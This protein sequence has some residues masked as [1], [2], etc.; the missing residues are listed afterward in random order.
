MNAMKQHAAEVLCPG[1]ADELIKLIE[2]SSE[3]D[4]PTLEH[5]VKLFQTVPD[6]YKIPVLS[7]LPLHDY[8][9]EELMKK[10]GCSKY[11]VDTARKYVDLYGPMNHDKPQHDIV[12]SRLDMEKVEHFLDFICSSGML[13]DVAVGTSNLKPDCG[14]EITVARAVRT[15]LRSHVIQLYVDYCKGQDYKP[16]SERKLFEILDLTKASQRKALSGLDNFVADGVEA[17]ER[18]SEIVSSIVDMP[19]DEKTMTKKKLEQ[20]KRYLKGKYLLDLSKESVIGTHCSTYSLSDPVNPEFSCVCNHDHDKLCDECQNMREVLDLVTEKIKQ[21]TLGEGDKNELLYDCMQA[22]DHIN[23]WQRHIVRGFQQNLAK[24]DIANNLEEDSAIWLCDWG[25]KIL[26]MKYREKMEDWFGKRGISFHIDC[27]FVPSATSVGEFRKA[28][29]FTTLDQCTQDMYAVSCISENVLRAV[30]KDFPNVT[31]IY[32]RSDNAGCYSGSA[33]YYVKSNIASKL[34]LT[35]LRTDFSEAQ[36][37]K[38]Q[39]DRE[40]AVAKHHMRAYVDAG[41]DIT[42]AMDIKHALEWNGGL[43]NCKVSVV[44]LTPEEGCLGKVNIPMVS[45]LHSAANSDLGVQVWQYYQIGEGRKLPTKDVPF[46]PSMEIVQDFPDEFPAGKKT[47]TGRTKKSDTIFFCPEISCITSFPSE[48]EV[49]EHLLKAEHRKVDDIAL[50]SSDKVRLAYAMTVTM[51]NQAPSTSTSG[52]DE[53]DDQIPEMGWARKTRRKVKQL[54]PQQKDWL[55]D[56]YD[57]GEKSKRKANPEQ[58]VKLMRKAEK[59]NGG[60]T[61]SPDEYLRKEQICSFFSRLTAIRRK[62]TTNDSDNATID[63]QEVRR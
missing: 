63:D 7:T 58:V 42:T 14:E 17:F 3:D 52:Q 15:N 41:H 20:A 29:Y 22:T 44:K 18:M 47:Q 60:K 61:F 53:L 1:Q 59:H 39:C 54:T 45:T 26:P 27:F 38:D 36:K 50:K 23:E 35:L 2:S 19:M 48:L 62:K 13:Q 30:K 11:M 5:I 46:V 21:S 8:S 40:S 49:E 43:R 34:G 4:D 28:T 31:K 9:K 12:R 56:I 32:D 57:A 51:P 10:F 25:I 55:T 24:Q 33:L 16:I 6:H 37:G